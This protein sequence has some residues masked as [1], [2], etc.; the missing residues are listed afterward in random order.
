MGRGLKMNLSH[1]PCHL[2]IDRSLHKMPYVYG[3]DYRRQTADR[4]KEWQI[5]CQN[6][7][8]ND[9]MTAKMTGRD[10]LK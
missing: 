9:K 10:R 7:L 5:N 4:K 2:V 8:Q 3:N 6:N 1:V